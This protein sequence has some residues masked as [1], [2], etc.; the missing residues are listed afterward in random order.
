M[1]KVVVLSEY[2]KSCGL[3]INICP[4]KVLAVGDKPNTKGY[5]VVVPAQPDQCIG[6]GLC[7]TVCP[8]MALELYK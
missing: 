3:C 8:D 5:Y 2:C 6:C 1:A 4:K 7:C